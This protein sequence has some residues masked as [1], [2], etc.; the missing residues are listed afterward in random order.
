[1][2]FHQRMLVQESVVNLIGAASQSAS[3]LAVLQQ[4]T[5]MC[6]ACLLACLLACHKGRAA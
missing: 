6:P 5:R 4:G 1:M 3:Q 2:A